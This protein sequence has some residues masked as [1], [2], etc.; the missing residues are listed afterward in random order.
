MELWK[1]HKFCEGASLAELFERKLEL[2]ALMEK[3]N[4]SNTN[5]IMVLN[6]LDEYIEL[7]RLFDQ[8]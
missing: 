5:A 4:L 2:V 6:V 8:D 7:K 1:I 3:Q